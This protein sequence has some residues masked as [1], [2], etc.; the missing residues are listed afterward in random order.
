MVN[1][2]CC[3]NL[4]VFF[5]PEVNDVSPAMYETELTNDIEQQVEK[6]ARMSPYYPNQSETEQNEGYFQQPS[7]QASLLQQSQQY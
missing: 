2:G 7:H 3:N 1:F 5:E 6:F 4:V